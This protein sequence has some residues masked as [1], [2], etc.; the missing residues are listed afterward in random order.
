MISRRILISTAS[1]GL[2][3]TAGACSTTSANTGSQ[4]VA[5]ANSS[6]GA[7]PGASGSATAGSVVTLPDG[8]STGGSNGGNGGGGGGG[9]STTAPSTKHT[10]AKATPTPVP[11]IMPELLSVNYA[12]PG[13]K[14]N[15]GTSTVVLTWT[16]KA[17]TS[18]YI[19]ESPVAFPSDPKPSGVGPLSAN[20]SKSMPFNCAYQYEYYMVGVYSSIGKQYESEQVPN[21]EYTPAP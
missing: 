20:G 7:S 11:T 3:L 4:S 19:E 13:C 6:I 9:S 21:P 14:S 15:S 12:T 17:A 18:A 5:T 16:S 2:V 8:G 10:T 1:I